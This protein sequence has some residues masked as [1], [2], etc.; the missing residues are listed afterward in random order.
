MKQLNVRSKFSSK[1]PNMTY[2]LLAIQIIV[3]ILMTFSGGSTNSYTLIFFGAKFNPA[4][5]A[6][7][8]WR[9]ITP[10]FL[11]I[12]FTHILMNSIT[13]YF[14]GAEIER[15]YGSFRFLIIYLLGGIMGN[16]MSFAFSNSLSAGASTSLFGLFAAAIVLGRMYPDNYAIRHMAQGFTI[17]IV[18]NFITGL[19]SSSID[20]WGHLGGA[21]GG[22]LSALFISVP[23]YAGPLNKKRIGAGAAYVGIIILLIFIGYTRLRLL[24]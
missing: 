22:A 1:N 18:L 20:N 23:R 14:L 5:V 24:Y 16:V 19:T 6:G 2:L 11:H 21:I 15:I 7:Q 9:F 17:L 3:F 8:Y 13:L 10:M 4:I 12:G